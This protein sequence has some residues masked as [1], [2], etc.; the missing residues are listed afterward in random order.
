[1]SNKNQKQTDLRSTN[2]SHKNRSGVTKNRSDETPE[3]NEKSN[4]RN[5]SEGY[6]DISRD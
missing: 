3:R 2:Q 4:K 5:K 1:M 6:S